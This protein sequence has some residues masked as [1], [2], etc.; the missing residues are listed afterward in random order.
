MYSKVIVNNKDISLLPG[1]KFDKNLAF[2]AEVTIEIKNDDLNLESIS[3][4]IEELYFI[5][6]R[7]K[8]KVDKYNV[9]VR[10][11][12]KAIRIYNIHKEQIANGHLY[13][14]LLKA[15]TKPEESQIRIYR[16]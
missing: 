11:D 16:R 13:N 5:L 10:K 1:K 2:P 9:L 14:H 8:C 15:S 3:S 7:D 6:K 12:D 4:M